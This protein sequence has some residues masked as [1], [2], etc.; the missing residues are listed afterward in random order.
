MTQPTNGDTLE[1]KRIVR[2]LEKTAEMAQ[3]AEITGNLAER[4]AAAV[5]S[6]NGI[7]RHLTGSGQASAALFPLLP[8]DASLTDVALSSAQLAEYLRAG[9]PEEEQVRESGPKISRNL[10]IGNLNLGPGG[11]K[12]EIAQMVREN[13]AEWLRE[14]RPDA[15][16]EPASPAEAAPSQTETPAGEGARAPRASLPP[17]RARV[18][19]LRSESP[20]TEPRH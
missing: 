15:T 11:D 18:E 19:E 4:S 8:D 14:G 16:R 7:V 9:L 6:Y 12:D 17:Q 2:M 20:Q 3:E 1:L 13:L 5:R 10:T